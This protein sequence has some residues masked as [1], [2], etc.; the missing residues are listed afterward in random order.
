MIGCAAID[1]YENR[2]HIGDVDDVTD[3]VRKAIDAA[4]CSMRQLA[5]AAG[6]DHAALVRI[7]SG[8]R[9]ATRDVAVRVAA[10]LET[11]AGD[12]R[13]SARTIRQATQRRR[14]T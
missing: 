5:E 6:V 8:E 7:R 1:P 14:R 12:C 2:H 3:A 10:A 13:E 9:T 11:W 4:P